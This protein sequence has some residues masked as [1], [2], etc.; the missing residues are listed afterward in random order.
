MSLLRKKAFS[1]NRRGI[2]SKV[3]VLYESNY[4]K[5]RAPSYILITAITVM[6]KMPKTVN[7]NVNVKWQTQNVKPIIYAIW[8]KLHEMLFPYRQRTNKLWKGEW[9]ICWNGFWAFQLQFYFQYT[10]FQLCEQSSDSKSKFWIFTISFS[11]P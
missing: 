2:Y 9:L 1:G 10:Y 5:V 8:L 6:W 4:I 7:E 11:G 3:K